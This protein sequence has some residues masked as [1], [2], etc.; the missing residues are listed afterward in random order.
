MIQGPKKHSDGYLMTSEIICDMIN[1][2]PVR[3]MSCQLLYVGAIPPLKL[4]L[5]GTL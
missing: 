4:L 5:E 2:T 3:L 1:P